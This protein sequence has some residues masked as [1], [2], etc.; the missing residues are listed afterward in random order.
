GHLAAVHD[1]LLEPG[2]SGHER[3]FP[4][5]YDLAAFVAEWPAVA[6]EFG[7]TPAGD[8]VCLPQGLVEVEP[9]HGPLEG[10]AED[11]LGL[12]VLEVLVPGVD[13]QEHADP[14]FGGHMLGEALDDP[15]AGLL[16]LDQF[17]QFQG[18]TP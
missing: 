15:L 16:A 4:G 12:A 14:A 6:V 7:V 9:Q 13:G 10:G 8:E 2:V 3:T 18:L 5:A 11:R 17:R 1:E